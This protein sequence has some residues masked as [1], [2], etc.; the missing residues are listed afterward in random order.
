VVADEAY[1]LKPLIDSAKK[2]KVTCLCEI[3][4]FLYCILNCIANLGIIWI[5]NLDHTS[6]AKAKVLNIY[7]REFLQEE[8]ME[9]VAQVEEIDPYSRQDFASTETS[10]PSSV[11]RPP[12][13]VAQPPSSAAPAPS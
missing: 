13:S 1:Y 12:S 4:W 5:A 8:A 9:Q 7:S 6:K 2:E 10:T 11:D 3:V